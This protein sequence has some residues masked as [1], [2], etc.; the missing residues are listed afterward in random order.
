MII[1]DIHICIWYLNHKYNQM[2]ETKQ[3]FLSCGKNLFPCRVAVK[4]YNVLETKLC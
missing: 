4:T 2:L 1:D 3:A